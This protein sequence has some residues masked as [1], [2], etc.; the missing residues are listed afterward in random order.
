MDKEI[1]Y[2]KLENLYNHHPLNSFYQATVTISHKSSEVIL[3]IKPSFHHAA[4]A[5]HGAVYWKLLD[6]S[7]FFA[8]NSV[9]ENV[10]VLTASFTIYLTQPVESGIL[11]AK[12][13]LVYESKGSQLLAESILFNDQD[14]EIARGNGVYIR[15]KVVLSPEIGYK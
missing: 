2:R 6:D 1:H 7:A 15:S 4:A 9:V 14:E 8:A 12:G 13:K 11:K 5:V 3:N 10:F